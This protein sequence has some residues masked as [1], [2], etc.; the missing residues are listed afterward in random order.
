MRRNTDFS[1]VFYFIMEQEIWKDIDGFEGLYKV[2]NLGRVK[3]LERLV[4]HSATSKRL[5]KDR[6]LKSNNNK[7]YQTVVLCDRVKKTTFLVHRLVGIM[8]IPNENNYSEINHKNGIKSDNRMSNLEWCSRSQNEQHAYD[9]GLTT[10]H[11]ENH[12]SSKLTNSDIPKIKELL[13]CGLKQREIAKI[14]NVSES[15]I[16]VIKRVVKWKHIK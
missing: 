14:F 4:K 6:I 12:H 9:N 2:S 15:T 16:S 13:S 11:S 3:S 10:T 7:R 1:G 5:T 8:F